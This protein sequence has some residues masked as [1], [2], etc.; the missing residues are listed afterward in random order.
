MTNQTM[1]GVPEKTHT[2]YPSRHKIGEIVTLDFWLSGKVP[3]CVIHA[4]KFTDSKVKYDLLVPIQET[5]MQHDGFTL[6]EN[7]DSICV[8][9]Y[10]EEH[11]VRCDI[12]HKHKDKNGKCECPY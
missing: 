2:Y 9:D 4:V 7:V 1:G 6:I 11:S 10:K 12:C 3:Q 5:T 8:V